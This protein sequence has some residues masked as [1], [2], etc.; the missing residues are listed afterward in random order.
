VKLSVGIQNTLN[1]TFEA[2][3]LFFVES[4]LDYRAYATRRIAGVGVV[5]GN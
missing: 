1:F 4:C 5:C 2:S 3:E